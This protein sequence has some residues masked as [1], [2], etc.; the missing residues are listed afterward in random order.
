[1][2]NLA[3]LLFFL[4]FAYSC[5]PGTKKAD[6]GLPVIPLTSDLSNVEPFDQSD[7]KLSFELTPLET[8]DSSLIGEFNRLIV[9][10]ERIF[11]FE[12]NGD[13]CIFARDGKFVKKLTR[14]RAGNEVLHPTDIAFDAK[15]RVLEVY[16]NRTR[17]IKR[18]DIDGKYLD[19]IDVEY[20]ATELEVAGGKRVFYDNAVG[21]SKQ[22]NRFYL[23]EDENGGT[24]YKQFSPK[25]GVTSMGHSGGRQLTSLDNTIYCIAYYNDVV[26]RVTPDNPE[27]VAFAR[28]DNTFA[29]VTTFEDEENYISYCRQKGVA[30]YISRFRCLDNGNLWSFVGAFFD[31][32][33]SLLW[34]KGKNELYKNPLQGWPYLGSNCCSDG[35]F[36]YNPFPPEAFSQVNLA[37]IDPATRPLYD[38]I[39]QRYSRYGENEN[40]YIITIKYER[41]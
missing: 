18:F 38:L 9:T 22:A 13:V 1:M 8:S 19:D 29:E 28:F 31:S 23:M 17:K 4:V 11:T 41:K 21:G 32:G 14:G 26:Y 24:V 40:P 30:E 6:D 2:R 20:Y 33:H 37:T 16:E 36:G 7:Y 15:N 39:A 10:P 35:V 27:P 25:A 34:D 12:V 3:V 5:K